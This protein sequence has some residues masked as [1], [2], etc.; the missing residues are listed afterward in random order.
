M[1]CPV[2]D[3]TVTKR[4]TFDPQRLRKSDIR[5]H[6]RQEQHIPKSI[7]ENK[8]KQTQFVSKNKQKK[9]QNLYSKSIC[10][11]NWSY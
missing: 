4:A 2:G 6:R 11:N 3:K 9:L 10:Q 8:T 7:T 5:Y 1:N